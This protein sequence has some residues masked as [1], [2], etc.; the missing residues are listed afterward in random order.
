MGRGRSDERRR[1]GEVS[2]RAFVTG[3]ATAFALAGCGSV[4][5][6]A[7]RFGR[8]PLTSFADEPVETV[9]LRRHWSSPLLL[10]SVELLEVKR[11]EILLIGRTRD[12]LEACLPANGRFGDDLPLF[13]GR[14]LPFFLGRDV[15]EVERHV[16]DC[17]RAHYKNV[18]LPFWNAVAHL[19]MLSLELVGQAARKPVYALA[20]EPRRETV[21]VYLSSRERST[22][23]EQ[24]IDAFMAPRVA[25]SGARAC[26]LG[27]GGRMS[28]NADATPGRS[29]ALVARARRVLGEDFTICVDANGSYDAANAIETGRMLERHRVW[30]FEEPCPFEEFVMTRQ[31]T[32]ALTVP[33]AG[34]EQDSSLAKWRWMID[35]RMV[36]I[37]QPDLFYAG[38]FLRS[39]RIARRAEAR[40]LEVVP[41]APRAHAA[42]ATLLHFV[43]LLDRPGPYHEFSARAVTGKPSYDYEPELRVRDG[44]LRVPA[45]PGFGI[46]YDLAGIRRT[47]RRIPYQPGAAVEDE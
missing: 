29:E 8:A 7:T 2:R 37:V 19:E 24:E 13:T 40:G 14:V 28:R 27:I 31:V 41:H 25:A 12:G 23:P 4:A 30:F 3:G 42:S 15:R 44:E 21:R 45:G 20:G 35:E 46:T 26:K 10:E 39:L 17:H 33:V 16:A 32:A 11:G 6:R 5:S 38:G 9:D 1:G 36:D 43:A 18:G 47:A 34:G 22:T